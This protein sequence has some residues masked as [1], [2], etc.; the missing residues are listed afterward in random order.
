MS[1]ES[2]ESASREQ[3]VDELIAAIIVAIDAGQKVDR[4]EWVAR[5]PEFAT[6]LE[7][8]FADQDRVSQLIGPIGAIVGG[9]L[10]HFEIASRSPGTANA[11]LPTADFTPEDAR[12][13]WAERRSFGPY[14]LLEEIGA[15]G[16]G[17]VFKARQ[18]TPNRIIALKL[19]RGGQLASA[20]EIRRFRDEA[21]AIA[22]LDHA[23]IVP[24]YEAG[25][26]EGHWYFSMRLMEGGSLALRLPEYLADPEAAAR[27]LVSVARAV[28]HAHR[29]GILHRDLKPSNVL[30]DADS[31]PSVA[32][33]GLAKRLA[34]DTEASFSG[35]I[36][37]TPPYMAPEQ[38]TGRW[39]VVTTATDVYGLGAV[40]YTMLTGGPPFRG[41][42]PLE[43]LEQVE[44][45]EPKPPSGDNP[46]VDR[47]LETIC[48]TCL[49]KDPQ[50]R[51][52]SADAVADDLE[53]WLA[54]K[55]IRA[56]RTG[57]G[58]RAVKWARRRPAIAALLTTTVM[59]S[60]LGFAG[61]LW[62]WRN[63]AVANRTL[64]E[65]D[66]L[67]RIALTEWEWSAKNF[68][69][70]VGL[71]DGC[72][73]K[74]R[75]WEWF[76]LKRLH[77][78]PARVLEH[79]GTV[80]GLAFSPDGRYLA[81]ACADGIVRVWD[82]VDPAAEPI[83]LR[84]HKDT[85][86]GIAF[87][88]QE[89]RLIVAS[90]S[91][92]GTVRVWDVAAR[93]QIAQNNDHT[94]GAIS[95][96][97]SPD[98]RRIA[99]TGYDKTV[100]IWDARTGEPLLRPFDQH[101]NNVLSVAFSHDS[102]RIA[103]ADDDGAVKVWDATTG[104][105]QLTL[106][107]ETDTVRCVAFSPDDALIALAGGDG[108]VTLWDAVTGQESVHSRGA[109]SDARRGHSDAV[110]CVAFN[111]IPKF[112]RIASCGSD[113]TIKIWNTATG[114]EYLTLRGHTGIVRSV[115][116]SPDGWCLA[117]AGDDRTVRIWDATRDQSQWEALLTYPGHES[118][119]NCVAFTP[120][121]RIASVGGDH[122]IHVW[123]PRDGQ[124]VFPPLRGHT[125]QL[126]CVACSSDG[127]FIASG[128]ADGTMRIWDAHTGRLIQIYDDHE[129]DF[130]GLA[131]NNDGTRLASASGDGMVRLHDPR[132][133]QPPRLFNGENDK[134][135]CVAFSP[136]L[137][138]R[139]FA[140]GSDTG[141]IIIWDGATGRPEPI[142]QL[143]GPN[144]PPGHVGP[145]Y[146]VAYSP[147]G[148]R[149]ASAGKDRTIRI[150]DVMSGEQ[151]MAPFK[152][153]AKFEAVAF[154]P[155]G[156]Y[157][158]AVNADGTI[159][160]LDPSTL[161]LV[162]PLYG[163]DSRVISAAFSRDGTRLA[164]AGFDRTVRVWDTTRWPRPYGALAAARGR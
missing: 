119:V 128:G 14:E 163:H 35:L 83:E 101:R 8:F 97:F 49:R 149:L 38:A 75:G 132:S 55:P 23:H 113:E 129:N 142:R 88:P 10:T 144:Q 15:G 155:D 138:G 109:H 6:E 34:P 20:D 114:R 66:Y 141:K 32:D 139:F 69:R 94:K 26:H 19:I 153:N 65:N 100:R 86:R 63:A 1:Q 125:S 133:S 124:R 147:D 159:R 118:I 158:V 21:D 41:E 54:G 62:A 5:H 112:K 120:G 68:G 30:F 96:A 17:I 134:L 103:S 44:L 58:E 93:S 91:Q 131:F 145:V 136:S 37:G 72:P 121:G 110:R 57:P 143:P 39:G 48:L 45:R 126:Y 25:E 107:T 24:I 164:S 92:D 3:E 90:A 12:V 29:H 7:E 127:R 122:A 105:V 148:K 33:F 59:V 135:W 115:A 130:W 46:R 111:P 154:S 71:L 104:Q 64:E 31:Q 123:D 43:V 98:G 79:P 95:V 160:V 73:A 4:R 151:L 36:V 70:A 9:E 82:V 161:R 152:A 157:L 56:R 60:A 47:D 16:Q 2:N 162:L 140:A 67:N 89:D 80:N 76:F 150:W 146:G 28:Q 78:T 11:E 116:F 13:M 85:I 27:L 52:G 50:R 61:I 106:P 108:V 99:S 137:N 156:L 117:S 40:L 102:K 53:R 74:L 42:S 84:G 77:Q 18:R 51:Y 87:S 81:T 22:E